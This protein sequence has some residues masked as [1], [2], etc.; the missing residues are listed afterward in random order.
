MK[1]SDEN[2]R[3][4]LMGIQDTLLT[5]D[6]STKFLL[7]KSFC[8]QNLTDSFLAGYRYFY[9]FEF[10][11]EERWFPILVTNDKWLARKVIREFGRI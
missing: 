1:N 5:I 6:K 4:P 11:L 3:I 9:R 8:D 2:Y 7:L 10:E